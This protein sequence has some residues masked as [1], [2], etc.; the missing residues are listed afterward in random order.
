MFGRGGKVGRRWCPKSKK[1]WGEFEKNKVPK[2]KIARFLRSFLQKV[3]QV[4]L[5]K[6]FVKDAK[7]KTT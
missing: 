3:V 7:G 1:E 5:L 6:S 4:N 2:T